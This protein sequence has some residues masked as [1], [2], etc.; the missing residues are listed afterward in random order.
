MI[1][2]N[3]HSTA[4]SPNCKV[5]DRVHNGPNQLVWL[6]IRERDPRSFA[7]FTVTMW[8]LTEFGLK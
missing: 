7:I 4:D 3:K 1:I 5:N 2:M 8:R 6:S